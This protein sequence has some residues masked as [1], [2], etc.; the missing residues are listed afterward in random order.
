[1]LWC[2][3]R[4]IDNKAD[5]SGRMAYWLLPR[6]N[7]DYSFKSYPGQGVQPFFFFF[8]VSGLILN[9]NGPGDLVHM[10]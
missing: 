8:K 1:M 7:L 3:Y 4:P 10:G 2:K 9:R 6:E 5:H